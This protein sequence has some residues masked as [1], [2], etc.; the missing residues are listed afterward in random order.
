MA[1]TPSKRRRKGR[2]AFEP[3]CD[4]NELNPWLNEKKD[5][6]FADVHAQDW[7]DGWNEAK[8]AYLHPTEPDVTYIDD[9]LAP[10]WQCNDCGAY[11]KRIEDIKHFDSCKPGESRRW[12]EFYSDQPDEQDSEC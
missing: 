3:G 11:A 2:E 7:L 9:D 5:T 6:W 10:V 4:P 8:E 1:E 12:Q